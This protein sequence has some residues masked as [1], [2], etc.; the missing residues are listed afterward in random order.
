MTQLTLRFPEPPPKPKELPWKAIFPH[1]MPEQGGLAQM[2]T[3]ILTGQ[4]YCY[5]DT[6]RINEIKGEQVACTVEHFKDDNWW[7][8]GTT[9]Q[10]TLF[11]LWPI[12]GIHF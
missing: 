4:G 7:K 6:V 5:G 3:V 10:C 8:N 9:Y 2:H 1:W 12:P 11:D